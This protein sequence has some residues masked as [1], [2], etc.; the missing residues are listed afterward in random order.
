MV[1]TANDKI[2]VSQIWKKVRFYAMSPTKKLCDAQFSS[3]WLLHTLGDSIAL[4]DV[5]SS[6][7]TGCPNIRWPQCWS[8]LSIFPTAHVASGDTMG[9]SKWDLRKKN[10]GKSVT[11]RPK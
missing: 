9:W 7:D 11:L 5:R 4:Y 8:S 3:K 1:S 2:W 10:K 6:V